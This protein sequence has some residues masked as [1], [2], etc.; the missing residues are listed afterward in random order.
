MSHCGGKPRI[1]GHSL[2]PTAPAH[3]VFIKSHHR[4]LSNG[5]DQLRQ[6]ATTTARIRGKVSRGSEERKTIFRLQ[7]F[8]S[9]AAW[10][11]AIPSTAFVLLQI[12][13]RYN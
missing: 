1:N 5:P 6:L 9:G 13:G 11:T 3:P 8:Q 2:Q 10:V 4:A 7:A 12:G